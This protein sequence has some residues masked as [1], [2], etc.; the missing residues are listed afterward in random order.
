[1]NVSVEITEATEYLHDLEH[2]TEDQD[3]SLE[4]LVSGELRLG[5]PKWSLLQWPLPVVDVQSLRMLPDFSKHFALWATS[6]ENERRAA[7]VEQQKQT[8]L[9]LS[10]Q[11]VRFKPI[12]VGDTVTIP[13]SDL[14][15]GRCDMQNA[16]ALVL[17][18]ADGLFKLGT[19][20]GVL[21]QFYSRNQINPTA[22]PMLK[23][24]QIPAKEVTLRRTATLT[25]LEDGSTGQGLFFCTC[26]KNRPCTSKLCK[27]VKNNRR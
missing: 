9:M 25:S 26:R 4:Q 15:R 8:D 22:F 18:K 1:M 16:I 6:Q 19:T 12:E 14:N 17:E 2:R 11:A 5:C 7:H 21:P 13:I 27:C 24:E 10:R 3:S 20:H 23:R